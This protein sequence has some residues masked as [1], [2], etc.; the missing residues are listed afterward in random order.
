MIGEGY[1]VFD[2][3]NG[4]RRQLHPPARIQFKGIGNTKRCEVIVGEDQLID[5][6][7]RRGRPQIGIRSDGQNTFL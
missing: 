2:V 7:G 3:Q 1:S 5:H 4:M 6:I